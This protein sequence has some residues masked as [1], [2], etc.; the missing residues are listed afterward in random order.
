MKIPAHL[1]RQNE[2]LASQNAELKNS[3]DH[4]ND[5]LNNS[6]FGLVQS[7]FSQ[8]A[9]ASFDPIAY[10][11]IYSPL[12]INHTM[13]T[14]MY[15]THGII[16]TAI[17]MPV[18]DALRGGLE[19]Q[20]SEL[21]QDE[22]KE[23]SAALDAGP[24]DVIGQAMV[25][26]R[27]YGGGGII[28]N[29]PGEASTPLKLE[30]FESESMQPWEII[31]PILG[32][33]RLNYS[34]ARPQAI[35]KDVEIYP[36]NRWELNSTNRFSEFYDFYG[37][38]IHSSRVLT[39]AG[40]AAPYL[41]RWT[42]QNWGMSEVEKMVED[43]NAYIR[44]KNV[45]YELLK[46]AKIDV[47]QFENFTTQLA[48]NRGT[49]LTIARVELMN[50]VKNFQNAV[51][52]DAKDK[53][54]QKQITFGGLAE[55]M[56]QN[57]IGIASAL[58][59]PMTKLFGLSSTGFNSGEDDIENYN[60]MVESEVRQPLRAVIQKVIQLYCLKLFGAEFEVTFNFKALRVMSSL[61]EETI[62]TQKHA[63]YVSLYQQGLLTPQ[64]TMELMQNEKLIPMET[65]VGRGAD[66]LESPGHED[67]GE[68][69][70]DFGEDAPEPGKEESHGNPK[71]KSA[72]AAE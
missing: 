66:P 55:V 42:L 58:R 7:A 61:D 31:S 43:F 36:V 15:K 45:V 62:K 24:L 9:L 14:Y 8:T 64:E 63:R 70:G 71:P 56:K 69:E 40:K 19:I 37:K 44:T 1:K 27:L 18:L 60:A 54:E 22:I 68:G 32:R 53:F 67:Q 5:Q 10:N 11:N 38:R 33:T 20:S 59:I 48:T 39:M 72:A 6:L 57:M 28:I 49:D 46:E 13:L 2:R 65:E 52:L 16:Q 26:A 51:V 50:R 35:L 3:I 29:A 4:K 21:S 12:T 41:I 25:W 47:Y 34:E 30:G 17:D 23:L